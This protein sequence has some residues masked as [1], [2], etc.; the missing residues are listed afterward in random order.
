MKYQL[1][2]NYFLLKTITIIVVKFN[3]S[4]GNIKNKI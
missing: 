4:L 1:I 2:K 3:I